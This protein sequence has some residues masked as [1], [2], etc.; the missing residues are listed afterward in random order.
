MAG[1][2]SAK[3][4]P[5]RL[6]WNTL[7]SA[8]Q[9]HGLLTGAA[10]P[11]PE[12][13]T[14]FQLAWDTRQIEDESSAP[15]L[16][17]ARKG[18]RFDGHSVVA[19]YALRRGIAVVAEESGIRKHSADALD[20]MRAAPGFVPVSDTQRALEVLL[21]AATGLRPEQF[22]SVAITGTSGKTSTTQIVGS[23]LE[24]LAGTDVLRMGTLGI[25]IGKVQREGAYP[26]MPDY[27]GFTE[28]LWDARNKGVKHAVFEATSHGLHERRMANWKV[29]VAVFLNLTQDHLDFH[30]TMEAYREAKEILFRNHL[31]DA[32]TAVLNAA[33]PSWTHM[34]KRVPAGHAV[35]GFGPMALCGDFFAATNG[36]A[37]SRT[38][39]LGI[40]H[41]TATQRG[42]T[43]RWHL[44]DRHD[45]CLQ[46]ASLSAPIL[47][48]FH[49]ENLAAAG[50][51]LLALGFDLPGIVTALGQSV[52]IPGRLEL[53][54]HA[55]EDSPTV[56][57]DYAHKPDALEKAIEA[58]R[59]FV[60]HGGRLVCVFGCGGDRDPTKRPVMGE[61]AA[62][63]ADEIFVTSDNPRTENAEAILDAILAGIPPGV[64]KVHRICD[65]RQA[66]VSAITQAQKDDVI[67]IA[68][69]GHEDYQI[70]GTEKT[71]FSDLEEA[72]KALLQGQPKQK[73]R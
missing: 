48:S 51:A 3:G 5:P 67:L 10:H 32:G 26:T 42:L 28:A 65:R 69:K 31:K 61:I 73:E 52:A 12:S 37:L 71:P 34:L 58:L 43:A 16:F 18:H 17:V 64:R 72:R 8:L 9:T 29:D 57:V 20:A 39:F 21:D 2:L 44:H 22:L 70:I 35:I 41:T 40:D 50:C 56:L 19:D 14:G 7:C 4:F 49:Q 68:G 38:L 6:Q 62:R 60:P 59:P 47:G 63:L 36:R 30:G 13:G 45:H 55:H 24:S 27:P 33:D 54:P 25:R 66:I 53:V 15:F 11:R 46:E 23:A 1:S